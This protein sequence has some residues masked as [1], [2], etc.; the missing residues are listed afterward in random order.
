VEESR[1]KSVENRAVLKEVKAL[2][3]P[4]EIAKRPGRLD[5]ITF[6]MYNKGY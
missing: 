2:P 4:S 3:E 5:T 6:S 1:T